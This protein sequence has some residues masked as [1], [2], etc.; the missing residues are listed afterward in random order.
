MRDTEP[1]REL[2]HRRSLAAGFSTQTVIDSDGDK[3]GRALAPMF[4]PFDPRGGH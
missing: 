2:L 1:P 4:D 3:F